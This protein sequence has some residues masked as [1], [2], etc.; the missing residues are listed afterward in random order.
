MSRKK[1]NQNIRDSTKLMKD[2]NEKNVDSLDINK[3]EHQKDFKGKRISEN[4]RFNDKREIRKSKLIQGDD[5]TSN[6]KRRFTHN[7]RK[8]IQ[9]ER[10]N[11][12]F[13]SNESK[14]FKDEFQRKSNLRV[15]KENREPI[16]EVY[17]PLSKDLDNDG[18]IDRYDNN[19]GD[20]DYYSSTYDVEKENPSKSSSKTKNKRKNYKVNE[21]FTRDKDKTH[22]QKVEEVLEKSKDSKLKEKLDD[23]GSELLVKDKKLRKLKH[24]KDSLLEKE[25]KE[26]PLSKT[27]KKMLGAVASSSSLLSTYVSHGSNE[28]VGAEGSEKTLD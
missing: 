6:Y 4:A 26:N 9:E 22:T 24:K 5:L 18:V 7:M 21:I 13:T 17:D 16:N 27:N 12:E 10:V 2:F 25:L 11:N 23:V 8:Q 28:N 20:S 14:T 15:F 1:K 19:V 3:L